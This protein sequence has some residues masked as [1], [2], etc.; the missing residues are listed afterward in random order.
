MWKDVF[1]FTKSE[2]RALALLIVVTI[3]ISGGVLLYTE[4]SEPAWEPAGEDG[5]QEYNDFIASLHERDN[6]RRARWMYHKKEQAVVLAPFDPNTAD[7]V[8]FV[9]LGLRPYIAKNIL[10]YRAKGGKFPTPQSFA[11]IYGITDVQFNTLLPY[12]YIADAFQKKQ[13][14]VRCARIYRKDTLRTFKYPAGTVIDL[15]TADTVELKKIPG[16]GGGIAKRIITYRSRLGGF[17]K[18]EQLQEITHVSDTLNRWFSVKGQPFQRINLNRSSIERLKAHPYLNFYQAKIIVEY[19]KKKGKLRSLKQLQLYEE[20]S[21][22]DIAR[23][24]HYVC[25]E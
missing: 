6:L 21:A 9:R 22:G 8:T 12:I 25:F 1:Y 3:S 2:R 17:Y 13:D 18:V 5:L 16:I 20:F 23:L 15:N 24:K 19:R 11:K 4:W 14:T 7:S 10:R